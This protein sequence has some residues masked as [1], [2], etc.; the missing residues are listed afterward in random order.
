MQLFGG[1]GMTKDMPLESIYRA[2]RPFR[3]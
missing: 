1:M 3:I 2:C